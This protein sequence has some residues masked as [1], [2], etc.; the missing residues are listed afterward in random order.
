MA[1]KKIVAAAPRRP[2]EDRA[3]RSAILLLGFPTAGTLLA[4]HWLVLDEEPQPADVI[5]VLAGDKGHRTEYS[6]SPSSTPA[7]PLI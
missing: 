6:V 5:V 3:L 7:T 2:L 4:G 1:V